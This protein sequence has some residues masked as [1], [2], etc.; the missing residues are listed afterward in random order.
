MDEVTP[1]TA[2]PSLGSPAH[3]HTHSWPGQ[4]GAG[5]AGAV[6]SGFYGVCAQ[7][8]SSPYR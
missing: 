3:T 7:Q 4:G 1:A 6:P 2:Q 8:G 5:Q